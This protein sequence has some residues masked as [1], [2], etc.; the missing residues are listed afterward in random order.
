[1]TV[2]GPAAT[3]NYAVITDEL[4]AGMVPVNPG[5]NN[6]QYGAADNTSYFSSPDVV[7]MD[8][9]Q[10]G[11][12]LSLYQLTSGQHVFTYRARIVSAGSF[13]VPPATVSL[14]YA[15][16]IYGWSGAQSITIGKVSKIISSVAIQKLGMKYLPIGI[17]LV[18]ALTSLIMFIIYF[19]K[20]GIFGKIRAGVLNIFRKKGNPPPESTPPLPI[21]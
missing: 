20:K 17:I 21:Q 18:I 15:P 1:L 8:V 6:E 10:N 3:E 12:V 14:M 11:A 13:S 16:E 19:K 5:F 2:T 7:G 4:P 9:T